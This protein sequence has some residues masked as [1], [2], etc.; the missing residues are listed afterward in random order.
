VGQVVSFYSGQERG[1]GMSSVWRRGI[2]WKTESN[3][4][5]RSV[6][7]RRRKDLRAH[8]QGLTAVISS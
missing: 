2:G 5:N 7:A 3:R 8:P 6:I 4:R 1:D